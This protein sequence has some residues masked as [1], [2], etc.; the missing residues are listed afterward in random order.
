MTDA[1]LVTGA[2]GLVGSATV[3]KLAAEGRRVVATDVDTP[4][5]RKAAAKIPANV[6]VRW[7]DLTDPA[8]VDELLRAVSPAAVIHLAAIIAPFCYARQAL[9]RKVNVD[10]TANL[11]RAAEAQP[12][13][14]RFI[15]ASSI[16][17]YG[18]RNP[19]T[20]SGVLTADTPTNPGDIYGGHKVEAEQLVRASNLEWA[21]LRLGGVLSAEPMFDMKPEFL[22]FEGLLPT[23]GRLQTV[24]VRD[25]A[26]AFAAATTAPVAGR[27]LLIGGDESHR[28]TQGDVGPSIAAAMGLVGAL[29]GGRKGNPASDTDWFATDWLDPG[30]AQQL[31]TFQHYSWPDIL[32][33]TAD[34][35]GWK[36]YP[37]RLIAPLAGG[38]LRRQA[39]YHD[40]PGQY[41][42][43]W[44]A[45][46][47]KWGEPGL[48]TD[49]D[50]NPV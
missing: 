20:V 27:V 32:A 25:V 35:V 11:I 31:L 49:P 40:H 14:P 34:R 30:P 21:I 43:P 37:L 45:I 7:A 29:P 12:T 10:A 19:H 48:D 26:A 5:T 6:E 22:Y 28:L 42:D 39:P 15:Q 50:G 17:V 9:A 36:R 1:V 18:P 8:A 46:R 2:F 23:D 38:Y 33:E 16:A 44:G 41:A 47:R 4:D 3:R 24:E 13:P